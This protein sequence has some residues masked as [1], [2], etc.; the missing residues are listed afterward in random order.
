MFIK[1][2]N[3]FIHI[4]N[5]WLVLVLYSELQIEA[6]SL[7]KLP[8]VTILEVFPLSS[9]KTKSSSKLTLALPPSRVSDV[10]QRV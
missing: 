1:I 7:N 5:A 6:I 3:D 9:K 4:N 10:L 2:K 8:A